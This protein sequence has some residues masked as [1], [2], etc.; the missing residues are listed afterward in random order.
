M[1]QNAN[2]PIKEK[3][4]K[5]KDAMDDPVNQEYNII[6][7]LD[8]LNE[9]GSPMHGAILELDESSILNPIIKTKL[10]RPAN[11]EPNVEIEN[12]PKIYK[13]QIQN[14]LTSEL[15]LE[16]SVIEKIYKKLNLKPQ[17]F[18]DYINAMKIQGLSLADKYKAQFM[19]FY[20]ITNDAEFKYLSPKLDTLPE[21][22]KQF[23]IDRLKEI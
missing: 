16:K 19:I 14:F 22:L 21:E 23:F 20:L 5:K 2:V 15:K 3:N 6:I 9:S 10:D 8:E 12:L 17:T 11:T 4:E 13:T 7:P 1:V 18:F